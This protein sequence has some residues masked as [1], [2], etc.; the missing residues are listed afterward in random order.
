MRTMT[1]Y[2]LNVHII[3]YFSNLKTDSLKSNIRDY[4]LRYDAYMIVF[5]NFEIGLVKANC[6]CNHRSKNNKLS[7]T[8]LLNVYVD[9]SAQQNIYHA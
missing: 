9:V 5:G 2:L 6:L 4:I 8:F 3:T 7:Y 1:P